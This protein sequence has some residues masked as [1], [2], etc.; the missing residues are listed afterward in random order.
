VTSSF[1]A[2]YEL[3]MLPA[4]DERAVAPRRKIP[5]AELVGEREVKSGEATSSAASDA[6]VEDHGDA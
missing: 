5:A 3:R 6:I 4:T 1:H 2:N